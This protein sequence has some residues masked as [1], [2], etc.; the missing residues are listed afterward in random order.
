[1]RW[2]NTYWHHISEVQPGVFDVTLKGSTEQPLTRRFG[3]GSP[4][5]KQLIMALA[6]EADD[7]TLDDILTPMETREILRRELYTKFIKALEDKHG[8]NSGIPRPKI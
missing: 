4:K 2:R 3:P 6:M 5:H 8:R 1:M 7:E